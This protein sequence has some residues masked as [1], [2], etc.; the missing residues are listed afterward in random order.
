VI[1]KKKN[2]A[3]RVSPQRHR[4]LKRIA[5]GRGLS[6]QGLLDSAID[7]QINQSRQPAT[8]SQGLL[9]SSE[10]ELLTRLTSD[11]AAAAAL[12]R[13]LM[14]TDEV[15]GLLKS[16]ADAAPVSI[17]LKDVAGRII[18]ANPEYAK[19]TGLDPKDLIGRDASQTWK[20]GD[21]AT[22][23]RDLEKKT[24]ETGLPMVYI[25]S[26]PGHPHGKSRISV[27]FPLIDRNGVVRLLT[28]IGFWLAAVRGLD[29]P[30]QEITLDD[31]MFFTSQFDYWNVK[32]L[33]ELP[34]AAV[35]KRTDLRIVWVNSKY[36]EVSGMSLEKLR[37][38]KISE[39]WEDSASAAII[40]KHDMQV[41][42]KGEPMICTERFQIRGT[43]G[44]RLRIRFPIRAVDGTIRFLGAIG[45]D[46]ADIKEAISVQLP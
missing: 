9:S 46:K 27:R 38:T 7:A 30:V 28:T 36:E 1:E 45:F 33:E 23:I 22:R 42:S 17:H 39:V 34:G 31:E 6:L 21:Y 10:R 16:V 32:F 13:P 5:E 25:H 18:W 24:L 44:E 3:I 8:L 14:L 35:V 41:L 11:L 15:S 26:L 4:E 2:L 43:E 40:E 29:R 12:L 37:N 19:L 20:D